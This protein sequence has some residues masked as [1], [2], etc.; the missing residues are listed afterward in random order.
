MKK[1]SNKPMAII[2]ALI[3][4]IIGWA[5]KAEALEPRLLWEKTM[6]FEI[7]SIEMAAQSGN[8][9]ISSRKARQII[10]YDRNGN[11]RFHLGPRIDRQPMGIGISDDGNTIVYTTSWTEEYTEKKKIDIDKLG[12]DTRVHYSTRRGKELWN[13]KI[14]G[15]ASLSPVGSLVAVVGEHGMGGVPLTVLDSKGNV[16]WKYPSRFRLGLRFSPDGSHILFY[17][18][19]LH[20]FDKSG[21]LLW[22]KTDALEADSVSEGATYITTRDKKVYDKQGNVI[23]E[24]DARVSGNGKKLIVLYANKMNVLSL[25][26]K[27]VMKEYPFRGGFLSYDGNFLVARTVSGNLLII[28]TLNQVSSEIY[29]EGK[30][31]LRGSTNDGKYLV[32]AIEDKK[33]LFYQVY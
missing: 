15:S 16:L 22:K 8:V 6:P 25:P 23:L 13:K 7:G 29:I 2:L 26:D 10:L 17:D 31:R 20:L 21:N 11:K 33:L 18:G 14:E 32:V 5:V 1:R 24:G 4:S 28:D 27:N 19:D 30:Y 3:I 12:W 9:I